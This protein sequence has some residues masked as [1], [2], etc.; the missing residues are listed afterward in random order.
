MNNQ[1]SQQLPESRLSELTLLYQFSN[2]MLST[3]RLNKLIH[4]ILTAITTSSSNLFERAF[5]FL[6]NEKSNV[7]QGMLAVNRQYSGDLEIV[8]TSDVLE[9]RWD[10]GDEIIARQRSTEL[11]LKVRLTR[12]EIDSGCPLVKQIINDRSLCH[13][14][15]SQ[16]LKCTACNFIR[17]LCNGSFAAVPLVSRDNTIGMIVVDNP[18]SRRE[19]SSNHIHFLQ[20][21]ANQAGMAIENSILYNRIQDANLSLKDARERLLH[22]ER[23]AAI[24][25]MA[26]NVAHELKNPLITIG[27]FAGRLLKMTPD[28]T[29]EHN[30]AGTI[31][32]EVGRLEKMLAEILA[33]SSKPSSCFTL[34][35]LEEIIKDCFSNCATTFEDHNIKTSLTVDLPSI[36]VLGDAHQLKQVFLNLILNS[37]D[38]MPEGGDL[39]ITVEKND[40]DK[41]TV[42]ITVL[43]SGGGI[44]KD[45]LPQIFNPF[46]TTKT[47]GTGLGLAIVNRIVINHFGS[48]DAKNGDKGTIF[49][50][51]LPLVEHKVPHHQL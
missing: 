37:C 29:Q 38:A 30:Y 25:E 14:D 51:T 40:T 45:M 50:I 17:P 21:F 42:I 31:V 20:L 43:D 13:S 9:S 35:N 32:S 11:C 28:G 8:G 46:F 33:F 18:D 27:G 22:G 4:L 36:A 5:L 10:I 41:R 15:A 39:N 3:I 44:P 34:C 47:H 6:R 19:I 12:V 23:L 48:I 24:G 49:T 26:A 7:L 1:E 2:T 16:C